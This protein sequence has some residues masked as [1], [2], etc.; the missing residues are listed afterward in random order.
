MRRFICIRY[1]WDLLRPRYTSVGS[2]EGN[3]KAGIENMRSVK[4]TKVGKILGKRCINKTFWYL[5]LLRVSSEIFF[6][7]LLR[8]SSV[9][10]TKL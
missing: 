3:V 6:I 8:F 9:L 5:G 4:G 1:F 7:S 2:D 10:I